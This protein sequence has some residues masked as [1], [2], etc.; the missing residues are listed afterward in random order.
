MFTGCGRFGPVTGTSS[1][2]TPQSASNP[3]LPAGKAVR[4]YS[5]SVRNPQENSHG[6]GPG[7]GVP[8]FSA[9]RV[10]AA[11]GKPKRGHWRERDLR[12]A[13]AVARSAGLSNYRVEIAPD[14][15]ISIVVSDGKPRGRR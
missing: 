8:A 6:T 9:F 3:F 5:S 4:P 1:S 12:R 11:V 7:S 14:G 2:L 10:E 15:T 13:F